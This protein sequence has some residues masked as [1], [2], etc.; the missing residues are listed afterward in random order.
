[1]KGCTMKFTDGGWLLSVFHFDC[2]WMKGLHWCNFAWDER[3]FP[4]PVGMLQRLKERGL[5][6]CVWINPY[7]A[8][9][10]DLF[11]E[12]K[13]HGYLLKKAHGDIWQSDQWQAG[14]AIVDF[15]NPQACDWYVGKLRKLLAMGVDCFKTD[16]GERI[17]TEVVYFDG[18]D[19]LKMH[20]YYAF[21][22]NKV[23]FKLLEN[24]RGMGE[25]VVFARAATVGSQQFPVHWGGDSNAT[26][27]SMAE[28]LRGGLSFGVSGFAF[29]C[30]DIGGF[31][32]SSTADLYKR[33]IAFGMLSSH[34]RLH[35]SGSYR[36]PWQYDD[37]AVDVLRFFTKLKCRLMPYLYGAACQAVEQGV[38]LLRAMILEFEH[39]P[40]CDYLDRQYMYGGALLVAPVFSEDGSVSFYLPRGTWTNFLTNEQ[41]EGGVW[42]Q[43]QH[44]YLSLPLYVR[45]DSIVALGHED[46][47]PDYDFAHE[48]ELHLFALQD[49]SDASTAVY[50]QQG[51]PE[52]R[53]HARRRGQKI[54]IRTAGA[55]KPW[56]VVLRGL[57][58]VAAVEGADHKEGANGIQIVPYSGVGEVVVFL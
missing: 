15:T 17:P 48:V 41:V 54:R 2:F 57:S 9:R 16:F 55:G 18:S 8:Q 49:G 11:A 58:A 36:V 10:S 44:G 29:W 34:S 21:L 23:V 37:E 56:R 39:D 6:I 4:D 40:A 33:W 25:A 7:I 22:Y 28:S 46:N 19:P 32:N 45:P 12:G 38:P 52:L 3:I 14:A 30:H 47:R 51:Q 20:N 24:E 53:V 27:A 35:G 31:E 42:R 43:E 5:R 1:M 13:A 50:N 26:Y